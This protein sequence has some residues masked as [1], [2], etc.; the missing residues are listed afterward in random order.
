MAKSQSV[1][2]RI[3]GGASLPEPGK[4]RAKHELHLVEHHERQQEV[5]VQRAEDGQHHGS[6]HSQTLLGAAK[7]DG[8]AVFPL[9]SQQFAAVPRGGEGEAEYQQC[10]LK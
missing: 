9:E 3:G 2:S 10:G 6:T 4:V 7:D 8:D 5:V 1:S